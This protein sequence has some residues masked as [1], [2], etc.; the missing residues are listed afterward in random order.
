MYGSSQRKES[1]GH[2]LHCQGENCRT[3]AHSQH[4][5]YVVWITTVTLTKTWYPVSWE[6]D[7]RLHLVDIVQTTNKAQNNEDAQK[8]LRHWCGNVCIVLCASIQ[9]HVVRVLDP[10]HLAPGMRVLASRALCGCFRSAKLAS[11]Q[12]AHGGHASRYDDVKHVI[13]KINFIHSF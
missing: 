3:S 12:P 13:M 2:D 6:S 1:R 10:A 9:C 11:G 5:V 7:V 8:D 4:C